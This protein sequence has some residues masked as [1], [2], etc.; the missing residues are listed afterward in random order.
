MIDALITGKIHGT[1]MRRTG[2]SG[3]P[4][5]VCKV[6]APLS[7][8]EVIFVSVIAFSVSV[9][10]ALLA[11][12]E[13]DSVSLTGSIVP[14]VWQP[15]TGAPKP[16]LDMVASAIL[17]IYHIDKRRKAVQPDPQT[18]SRTDA[19]RFSDYSLNDQ[20]EATI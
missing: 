2:S 6:R 17:T 11:L 15:T 10:D 8:N 12:G 1:P 3:K 13:G 20:R 4:F 19:D 14:K 18:P 16:T 5:T 9:G 7:D